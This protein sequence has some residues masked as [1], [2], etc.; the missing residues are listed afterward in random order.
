M[1]SRSTGW[2]RVTLGSQQG[3]PPANQPDDQTA[4]SSAFT[5]FIQK[6]CEFEGTLILDKSIRIEGEFR[7]AIESSETV[8]VDAEA[9]VEARIRARTVVIHGAVVGDLEATREVVLHPTCRLHGDVETPSL[10]VE[11]GAFFNGTTRMFR[12]EQIV[13][14]RAEAEADADGTD[15]SA[16]TPAP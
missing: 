9:A 11:R 15:T 14:A 7:G 5:T 8:V 10:V 16:P 12:P 4:A 6:G 13:R 3:E 1:E 2:K